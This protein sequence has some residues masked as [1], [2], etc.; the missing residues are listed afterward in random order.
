M[1]DK[2]KESAVAICLYFAMDI[3]PSGDTHEFTNAAEVAEALQKAYAVAPAAAETLAGAMSPAIVS[4]SSPF[5]AAFCPRDLVC[6]LADDTTAQ[7]FV[8]GLDI[9]P[10]LKAIVEDM[11]HRHPCP[12]ARQVARQRKFF[13]QAA[14]SSSSRPKA[15]MAATRSRHIERQLEETVARRM[16]RPAFRADLSLAVGDSALAHEL[17]TQRL[18]T[19]TPA[20]LQRRAVTQ[21]S[22][23]SDDEREAARKIV[24]DAGTLY[25]RI[26]STAAASRSSAVS[27]ITAPSFPST[28]I[29]SDVLEVLGD[30]SRAMARGLDEA[31]CELERQWRDEAGGIGLNTF[32]ETVFVAKV[33]EGPFWKK[34]FKC[35]KRAGVVVS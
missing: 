10:D 35:F 22:A 21:A 2:A 17:P 33:E 31:I 23:I 9:D 29:A 16:R 5:D 8:Q 32:D 30:S 28:E 26:A 11:L 19:T 14:P 7:A 13:Q 25:R 18:E 15:D 27:T 34:K 4:F 1:R 3:L 12:S 6:Q 24:K 20:P